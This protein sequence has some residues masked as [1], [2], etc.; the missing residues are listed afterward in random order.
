M[1][2]HF[3]LSYSRRIENPESSDLPFTSFFSRVAILAARMFMKMLLH[4]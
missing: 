1:I 2:T 4:T 3:V